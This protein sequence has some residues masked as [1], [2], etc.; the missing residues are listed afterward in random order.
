MSEETPSRLAGLTARQVIL[1]IYKEGSRVAAIAAALAQAMGDDY[2][3]IL[4]PWHRTP[5]VGERPGGSIRVGVIQGAV[6]GSMAETARVDVE[7]RQPMRGWPCPNQAQH[8]NQRPGS[9]RFCNHCGVKKAV[10]VMQ[11]AGWAVV[12]HSGFQDWAGGASREALEN[13]R[14]PSS[15]EAEMAADAWL[16]NAG[17]F[18]L[19][20]GELD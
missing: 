2:P 14:W 13:G 11:G 17:Y 16:H 4:L 9:G 6:S 15:A 5:S 10:Q 3:R 7:Y 12:L 8:P 1:E 20:D 18:P 19:T